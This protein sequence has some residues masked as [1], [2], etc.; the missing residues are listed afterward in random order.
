MM[1]SRYHLKDE[2]LRRF[3]SAWRSLRSPTSFVCVPESKLRDK[4]NLE[5]RSMEIIK[6]FVFIH[7][8]FRE[9]LRI[10]AVHILVAPRTSHVVRMPSSKDVS[11]VRAGNKLD[12]ATAH[13]H[14]TRR[15]CSHPSRE[16]NSL[17]TR[18][19]GSLLPRYL[20]LDHSLPL[21]GSRPDLLPED[22]L[23]L[24]VI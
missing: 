7:P 20:G 8:D 11:N 17:G 12:G 15:V 2:Q 13:P 16:S 9:S 5:I 18:S 21:R 24:L 3:R 19:P 4:I 6:T 23:P 10:G 22:R 1:L 14:L